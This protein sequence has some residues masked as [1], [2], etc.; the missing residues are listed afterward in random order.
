MDI[1]EHNTQEVSRDE[2]M[3]KVSVAIRR[4][5]QIVLDKIDKDLVIEITDLTKSDRKDSGCLFEILIRHS[6]E[7]IA[8]YPCSVYYQRSVFLPWDLLNSTAEVIF[9]HL[10]AFIGS[11]LRKKRTQKNDELF[12]AYI[13]SCMVD[14]YQ[15]IY[16]PKIAREGYRRSSDDHRFALPLWIIWKA[17]RALH[18]K[19]EPYDVVTVIEELKNTGNLEE[20]GGEEFLFSIARNPLP[21]YNFGGPIKI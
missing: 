21:S 3:K 16:Q 7:C 9:Q 6:P 8:Y 12:A 1:E 2:A 17:I 18:K 19:G 14:N 4:L 15:W 10:A 20:A 5:I 11:S 13:G